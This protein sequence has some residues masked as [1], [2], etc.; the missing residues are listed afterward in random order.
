MIFVHFAVSG[1]VSVRDQFRRVPD[2]HFGSIVG[3]FSS[4]LVSMGPPWG[5]FSDIVFSDNFSMIFMV[6]EVIFGGFSGDLR[7]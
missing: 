5:R 4:P 7:P 6:L 2:L 1:R 3:A